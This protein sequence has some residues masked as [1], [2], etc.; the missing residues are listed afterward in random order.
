MAEQFKKVV[1]FPLLDY[2]QYKSLCDEIFEEWQ[3]AALKGIHEAHRQ[4]LKINARP[5]C[6]TEQVE[7]MVDIGR[8]LNASED[9]K[10][11]VQSSVRKMARLDVPPDSI[12]ERRILDLKLDSPREE[13]RNLQ[14]RLR[15]YYI[16][17]EEAISQVCQHLKDFTRE[18]I[19]HHLALAEEREH[20][21]ER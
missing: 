6:E 16:Y 10:R 19:R 3:A 12:E 15:A 17:K 5:G 14:E 20:A 13:M 18:R 4:R 2:G 21:P 7:L 11:Y 1:T 9:Y 8:M